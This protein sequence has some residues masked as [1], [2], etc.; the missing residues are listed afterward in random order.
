MKTFKKIFFCLELLLAQASLIESSSLTFS[1]ASSSSGTVTWPQSSAQTTINNLALQS[2]LPYPYNSLKYDATSGNYVLVSTIPTY[3]F[4]NVQNSFTDAQSHPIPTGAVYDI[5]GNLLNI[6]QGAQLTSLLA[7]YGVAIDDTGKQVLGAANLQPIMQLAQSDLALSPG[8]SGTS[9]IYA[10]AAGFPSVGITSPVTYNKTTRFYFYYNTLMQTYFA[11]QVT[12]NVKNYINI[13]NGSVYNLDGSSM[14]AQ[15]PVGMQANNAKN[16]LLPYLNADNYLQCFMEFNGTNNT[17]SDFS[18][19]ESSFQIN[20]TDP[21]TKQIG[22]SNLLVGLSSPYNSVNVYQMPIPTMPI[23]PMPDLSTATTYNV[24]WNKTTPTTYKINT[25]YAWQNLQLLPIDM[26]SRQMLS[27]MPSPD[28]TRAAII[29]QSNKIYA[30]V[31]AGQFFIAAE[32]GNTNTYTL[33]SS[34]NQMTMIINVDNKTQIKYVSLISGSK[35]YNYQYPFYT[36]P[37]TTL[38]TYQTAVWLVGQITDVL[39]NV[40][41][42]KSLPVNNAGSVQLT[43]ITINNIQNSP[44]DP[45]AQSNLSNNIASI[46][47]D[48]VNKRFLTMVYPGGGSQNPSYSYINQTCY[49]DLASGILFTTQGLLTGATLQLADLNALLAQLNLSV[50]KNG[51]TVSL[52]YVAPTAPANPLA[53]AA[54]TTPI[55]STP[56]QPNT[57]SA[58]TSSISTPST[59]FTNN[60]AALSTGPIVDP[61]IVSLQQQNSTLQEQINQLQTTVQNLKSKN[62][63]KDPNVA[64]QL[65][66][67][68]NKITI[69]TQQ[70]ADNNKQIAVLQAQDAAQNTTLGSTSYRSGIMGR[71]SSKKVTGKRRK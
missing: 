67:N 2:F 45:T 1:I 50:I 15:N 37:A 41:L 43:P 22:A 55:T 21:A 69:D 57:T 26:T 14:V 38:Q 23:P 20:V 52:S 49:V 34:S 53:P 51:N 32:K 31:F 42:V 40:L 65:T 44:T 59:V 58:S 8:Q 5:N 18:N 36:L 30:V 3:T 62:K 7:Q 61:Q 70:I 63:P 47:Q 35:T 24:Y 9:M 25:Q 39:G 54:T 19:T 16:L 6:I 4:F 13:A 29:L 64:D 17:Y 11:M 27:S 68:Q 28:Y 66:I 10:T 33:T 56:A 48:T 12:G 71:L 46:A 60:S